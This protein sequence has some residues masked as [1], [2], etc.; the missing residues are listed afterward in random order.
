MINNWRATLLLIAACGGKDPSHDSYQ[1]TIELDDRV[2]SF[3]LPGRVKELRVARGDTVSADQVVARVVSL[4]HKT[5]GAL[6]RVGPGSL[7]R[8]RDARAFLGADLGA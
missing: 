2:L 4:H 5:R 7:V 8:H 6:D 1:G 3:E